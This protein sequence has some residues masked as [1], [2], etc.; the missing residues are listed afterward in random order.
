MALK[1]MRKL[2][3]GCGDYPWN[4]Q[5]PSNRLPVQQ[6]LISEARELRRKTGIDLRHSIPFLRFAHYTPVPRISKVFPVYRITFV[7]IISFCLI[8]A[9]PREIRAQRQAASD[10]GCLQLVGPSVFSFGSLDPGK[11][12]THAFVFK[13]N[14]NSAVSI[15]K[16]RPGCGCTKAS[17]T[18]MTIAPGKETQVRITFSP[19]PE[20]RGHVSKPVV[21]SFTGGKTA[22]VILHVSADV[23]SDLGVQPEVL[24]LP[25]AAIGS[26]CVGTVTVTNTSRQRMEQIES[27]FEAT[28]YAVLPNSNGNTKAI[29][30]TK[31]GVAPSSFALAP[32]EARLVT[33]TATPEHIGQLSGTLR[34][35]TGKL[36]IAVPVVC[37]VVGK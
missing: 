35:R 9:A 27:S 5:R 28:S 3:S 31:T 21:V 13:N 29:A 19:S 23:K 37:A 4:P 1:A 15:A 30:L 17:A 11:P 36:S 33:V 2:S 10:G 16:L 20:M 32:G 24:Q 14:C 7:S 25:N 18:S 6:A 26:A 22:E 12:V 34:I 8:I